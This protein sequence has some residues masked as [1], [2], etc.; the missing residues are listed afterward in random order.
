VGSR[1]TSGK[2]SLVKHTKLRGEGVG[3][4]LGR[5]LWNKRGQCFGCGQTRMSA[6]VDQARRDE[7]THTELE[8]GLE[9]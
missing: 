9:V 6:G 1:Q 7:L 3:N 8:R 4:H 2:E 5:T